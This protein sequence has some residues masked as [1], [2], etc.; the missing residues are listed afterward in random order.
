MCR[1][2]L[3]S[4]CLSYGQAKAVFIGRVVS[5]ETDYAFQVKEAFLNS[6]T[7]KEIKLIKSFGGCSFPFQKDETYLVYAHGDGAGLSAFF[8]SGTGRL[9]LIHKN[10]LNFLRNLPK[11]SEGAEITGTAF[12]RTNVNA[13]TRD[14]PRASV[15]MRLVQ[16]SD[17]NRTLNATTDGEGNYKFTGLPAGKYKLLPDLP[18]NLTVSSYVTEEFFVNEKG[19]TLKDFYI[20]NDNSVTGNIVDEFDVPVEQAWIELLPLEA[21]ARPG[22]RAA[23]SGVLT[24]GKFWLFNIP[25]GRYLLAIN[26][27]Y[28]PSVESPYATHFVKNENGED[29][30]F[31]ISAGSKIENVRIKLPPKLDTIEA[32]GRII[33]PDGKPAKEVFVNLRDSLSGQNISDTETDDNGTFVIKGFADRKYIL[34][35]FFEEVIGG[36]LVKFE[37]RDVTFT[38][39]QNTPT[40][41]LV[42]RKS[43][44]RR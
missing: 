20:A 42:L 15:K 10:D 11:K 19:C 6:E 16:T 3:Y 2:G 26:Y 41:S 8:C 31:S 37:A 24:N 23:E 34:E 13:E 9:D 17:E 27:N 33:W 38:L 43:S 4:P 21:K 5:A 12:Y 22:V 14:R 29:R 44:N 36:K 7:G 28:L 30:I 32:R 1:P 40:F 25:P 35:T 18:A 39:T